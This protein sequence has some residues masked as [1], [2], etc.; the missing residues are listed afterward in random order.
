MRPKII[1]II[2]LI[3]V[4]VVA[5]AV[6]LSKTSNAPVQP[7]SPPIAVAPADTAPA[8]PAPA[9]ATAISPALAVT[10]SRMTAEEKQLAHDEYVE[11]RSDEFMALAALNDPAEHQKIVNALYDSDRAV[12]RAALDAL[13]QADDRSVIPDMQK[14]ADQT[15]DPDDKQAIQDAID[16]IKLPSLT[17]VIK[18]HKAT[19]ATAGNQ[20]IPPANN[21]P[22]SPK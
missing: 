18:A 13:E 16:F 22:D 17:E 20:F 11:K 2:F 10:N 3:A 19:K 1:V 7:P 6:K 9:S 5:I 21:S 14:A 15:D 12:R 4:F 8:A